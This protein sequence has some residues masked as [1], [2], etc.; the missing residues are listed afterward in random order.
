MLTV[1]KAAVAQDLSEK[2]WKNRLV[3]LLSEN[4]SNKQLVKQLADFKEEKEQL[5]E[6]K[7]LTYIVLPEKYKTMY[8]K[9]WRAN[10]SLY[11]H[12]KKSNS[13]FELVLIG[14]DGGI[15]ARKSEYL[16]SESLYAIID[17]MP[18]RRT[19]LRNKNN[20]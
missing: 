11:A 17:A 10:T 19:E 12:Y 15:K 7:I 8:G 1:N 2:Q 13:A 14:L 9:A 20:K 5:E 6:R 3:L 4:L 16:K 18:M